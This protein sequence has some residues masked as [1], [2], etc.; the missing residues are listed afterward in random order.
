VRRLLLLLLASALAAVAG[1]ASADAARLASCA[2][3]DLPLVRSGALTI[4][5][6]NPA[7]PPWFDGGTPK[8]SKWKLNDPATGKGFESA[9]AYAIAQQLGFR[10]GDVEWAPLGFNQSFRPGKKS[11]DLYFAQV[12]FSPAR[13]KAVDFSSSYYDVNQAVV[14]LKGS[15]I[16]NAGSVT[17]LRGGK[18]GAP[19]GTTS[20]DYIVKY[21]KP[22][23]KPAVYD[24]LNDSISALKAHQVDGIV[25]DLPTAFY[26]VAAQ[27]DGGKIVG[28]FRSVPG[29]EHFG[30]VLQKGNPL[31]ACVNRA[32]AQLKAS[33][34]LAAIQRTWLAR[35]TNAPV[36]R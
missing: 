8:G 33:G 15:K 34:R 2:K 25:V 21:V 20:Y 36:L 13:A 35:K 29:G 3:A 10:R 14:A 32:L 22:T 18:L 12:S 9:V 16:A 31:T 30:A 23:S 17:G 7:Y 11:F 1:T 28:Q 27:I 4:G 5:T 24:S 19:I 26:I 6:D